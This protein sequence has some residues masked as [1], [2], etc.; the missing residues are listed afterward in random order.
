VILSLLLVALQATNAAPS[1]K[2]VSEFARTVQALSE[3]G[4]FFWSDNLVSNE[5][6]YLHIIGK[7]D[8]LKVRGG[9][10]IGV[11]PEQNFSYIARIRP[12]VAFIVD[13][14]RDNL[15]LQ[16]LFKAVFHQ[17][18]N[19]LEYLCL[20]YA[21]PCPADV[22]PWTNRSLDEV[23][24]YLNRTVPDSALA[25]RIEDELMARVV[26]FGVPIATDEMT[27]LRRLHGE[28]ISQGLDLRFSAYGRRSIASFP[29]IREL[30]QARDLSGRQVSYLADEESFRAVQQ[31]EKQ[32]KII[33]V[34]GDL[35]G[36]HAVRAI[37]DYLTAAGIKVS[38]FYT[39]NVEFYLFRNAVFERFA[40]N[41]QALPL[42]SNSLISRSYFGVQTGFEH[43]DHAPGHLSVQLLQSA[44]KFVARAIDPKGITYWSLVTEELIP[45]KN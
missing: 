44:E 41:V 21:R 16:L 28:F 1:A 5:T 7:L 39:S 33:P 19:R 37:G 18:S 6:S 10:Y 34:V 40:A 43:P 29:T 11:G 2:A 14:R 35:A 27:T 25:E 12:A 9:A 30:Y 4:G 17:A 13:I 45:L 36:P 23:I 22:K 38:L 15:L 3:P 26:S 20:L 42:D 32:D 31:L 8:E 24:D